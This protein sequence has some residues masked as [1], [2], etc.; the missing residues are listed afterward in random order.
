MSGGQ[1]PGKGET[2]QGCGSSRGA[3]N[4]DSAFIST[5]NANKCE[6]A[7]EDASL[8]SIQGQPR[9]S[10]RVFFFFSGQCN[11]TFKSDREK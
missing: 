1:S 7:F 3:E 6:K 8:L 5:G 10:I 11:K 2:K 9:K 4:A